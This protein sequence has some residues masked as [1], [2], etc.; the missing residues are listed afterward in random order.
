M[1]YELISFSK[2]KTIENPKQSCFRC[3]SF[4][5]YSNIITYKQILHKHGIHSIILSVSK[6]FNAGHL[7]EEI[8]RNGEIDRE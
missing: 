4:V 6:R 2:V 3:K 5:A 8:E 1:E 7:R